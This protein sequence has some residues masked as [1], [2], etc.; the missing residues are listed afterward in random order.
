MSITA[1]STISGA[2]STASAYKLTI[3]VIAA[4]IALLAGLQ[5]AWALAAGNRQLLK[6]AADWAYDIVLYG[7][8]AAVFGHGA[9]VER[10][11]ALVVAGIMAVA[12]LHTLYDLWDKVENP[13]PIEVTT[14]GFSAA[15]AIAVGFAVVGALLRFRSDPNTLIKATWLT[16]R[17]D[18]IATTG[19]AIVTFA[20][21]VAPVRWPEYA[22][23][24]LG[25]GLCFQ[26]TFAIVRAARK[27]QERRAA[28][29]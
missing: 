12:G 25:A 7:L 11:S 4:G 9:R 24:V 5:A 18:A 3:W 28:D 27:D 13:R 10:I 15:S 29:R 17:N 14:L 22:L 8:A 26:A 6:D 23:D 20:T 2:R 16:A 19:F 1:P 21:R